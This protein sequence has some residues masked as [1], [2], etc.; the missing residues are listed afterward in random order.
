MVKKKGK[1][2]TKTKKSVAMVKDPIAKKDPYSFE[3]FETWKWMRYETN[4]VIDLSQWL[5]NYKDRK[6]F[7]GTDSQQ[8]PKSKRCVFTSVVVAW[9]YDE[10][11]GCGHGATVVRHVDKRPF[12]P[13]Q[14]LSARLTVEVQRSIEICKFVEN[15]L[16]D[17]SDAEN[18]YYK[19]ILAVTID[20]SKN[21]ID[22]S[23]RYKDALVGMVMAYGWTALVKP[24]AWAANKVADRKC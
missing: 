3:P 15:T 5:D 7:I 19:N 23:C 20:V 11:M 9:D 16:L 8:Y 12:I 22:L 10:A 24:D 18:E 6:F 17:L 21:D 1:G 4:E 13:I 14:A 2:K